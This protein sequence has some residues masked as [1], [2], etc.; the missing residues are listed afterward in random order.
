METYNMEKRLILI[1]VLLILGLLMMSNKSYA[2]TDCLNYLND[3]TATCKSLGYN[4]DKVRIYYRDEMAVEQG[5]VVNRVRNSSGAV[6]HVDLD[7]DYVC[8]AN[9]SNLQENIN[10][11]LWSLRNAYFKNE[12]YTKHWPADCPTNNCHDPKIAESGESAGSAKSE[13]AAKKGSKKPVEEWIPI[14]DS[15]LNLKD[16]LFKDNNNPQA[17][18]DEFVAEQRAPSKFIVQE[19]NS[20][21]YIVC[22]LTDPAT[23]QCTPLEGRIVADDNIGFADF[24]HNLGPSVNTSLDIWLRHWFSFRSTPMSCSQSM[25]CD[26][27]GHCRVTLTC[28]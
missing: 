8:S 10:N 11:A 19:R 2:A 27:E 22:M 5:V 12:F 9:C 24:T 7:F 13:T 14:I 28:R 16:R 21:V 1:T 26:S 17:L 18:R 25:S 20:G 4:Y 15:A 6:V 3:G 23:G